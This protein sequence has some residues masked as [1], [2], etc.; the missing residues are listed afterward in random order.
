M[1]TPL[2]EHCYALSL[3]IVRY[4][5]DAHHVPEDLRMRIHD[6]GIS[7]GLN[8][9]AAVSASDGFEFEMHLHT[10]HMHIRHVKYALRLL[11]D[12][13]L[14]QPDEATRMATTAESAHRLVVAAIRTMRS[15]RASRETSRETA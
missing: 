2:Q 15:N 10:V 8:I 7:L 4:S 11:D 9:A 1:D 5:L 6:I 14:I 13:E 3:A 12:L